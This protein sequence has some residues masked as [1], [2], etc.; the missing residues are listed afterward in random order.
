MSNP[1][2]ALNIHM[3]LTRRATECGSDVV[4]EPI[5]IAAARVLEPFQE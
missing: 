5:V 4:A 2:L 1:I 3:A